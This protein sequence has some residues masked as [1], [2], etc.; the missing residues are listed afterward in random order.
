MD[1]HLHTPASSDYEEPGVTYLDILKQAE[2]LAAEMSTSRSGIFAIAVSEF[3]QRQKNRRLFDKLNAAYS[4]MPD[5]MERRQQQTMKEKHR[6][7]LENEK[8]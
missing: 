8:W 4:D 6:H 2:E 5:D 3:I 7:F 1:L